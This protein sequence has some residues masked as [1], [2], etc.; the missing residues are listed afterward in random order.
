MEVNYGLGVEKGSETSDLKKNLKFEPIGNNLSKLQKLGKKLKPIHRGAF[1]RKYGNLLGLLELEIEISIVTTLAQFYDSYMR[2]FT[3]QDFQ[4]EP[5]IEEYEQIM[6][7]P[8]S[9]G[10]PYR[11]FEQH[12]SILTLSSITKIPEDMLKGHL[13]VVKDTKGFSQR[14]LEAYLLQLSVKEDWETFMD[15]LALVLYGVILFPYAGDH[16]DYAAMDIFVVVRTRSQNPV[17]TILADTYLALDLCY[18]RKVRKMLCSVHILCV[19]LMA[20]VGENVLG[21]RCPIELVTRKKLEKRS[22]K[23][24]ALFVAGLNQKKIIWQ[25]SWQQS[26]KLVYSCDGFPN[27]P[28]MGVRGCISYNPVL[29]QRQFDYPISGAPIPAVLA[30]LVCYYR[31]GFMTE[32]LCHIRSA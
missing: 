15:V 11:H 16:I 18:E 27:V 26:S 1:R 6:D 14:F 25:P 9:G 31:D 2:C 24:W 3:F 22:G 5:T 23:E 12:A 13:V 20:H 29:A 21:V 10:V 17:T 32:T 7:M 28:L 19:W 30:S 8:L 4:L